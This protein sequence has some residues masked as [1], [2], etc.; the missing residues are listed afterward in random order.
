[1]VQENIQAQVGIG[2]FAECCWVCLGLV[3]RFQ[4]FVFYSYFLALIASRAHQLNRPDI[5]SLLVQG[6]V[7]IGLAYVD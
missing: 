2:I 4:D 6:L 3:M 1:M 5:W 7:A